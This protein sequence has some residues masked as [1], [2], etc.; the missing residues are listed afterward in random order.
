MIA[1]AIETI[2]TGVFM[3]EGSPSGQEISDYPFGTRNYLAFAQT[4]ARALQ[5]LR[6]GTIKGSALM[7]SSDDIKRMFG[8]TEY[9]KMAAVEDS[10]GGAA[11]HLQGRF[12]LETKAGVTFD[13]VKALSEEAF[14]AAVAIA[15]QGT[16]RSKPR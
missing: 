2:F 5:L 3:A 16:A 12:G 8:I 13:E 15:E 7:V 6:K 1:H 11:F 10:F 14:Q 9:P 4:P